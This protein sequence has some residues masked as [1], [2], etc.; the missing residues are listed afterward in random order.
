VEAVAAHRQLVETEVLA[1]QELVE[2]VKHL[3]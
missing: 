2:L 3:L 1:L